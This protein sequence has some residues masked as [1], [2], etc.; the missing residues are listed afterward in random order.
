[1]VSQG[2]SRPAVVVTGA[3][4]GIGR[5]IAKVAAQEGGPVVLVARSAEGLAATAEAVRAAGGEPFTLPL[6]LS[7]PEAPAEVER[8]L[9]AQGLACD[10][11]VNNAGYGLLG[12]VATLPREDQLG[13]VDLNIRALT[14]LTLRFLPGMLV[15]KRGG[16]IK[17]RKSTRLN[18]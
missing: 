8:F 18:S 10:V 6:D 1:M 12:A 5:E 7:R 3:S 14:D 15:R 9:A 11:L 4:G 13:I 2:E 16:I 17:D